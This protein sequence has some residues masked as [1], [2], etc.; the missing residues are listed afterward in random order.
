[1]YP[2]PKPKPALIA[3]RRLQGRTPTRRKAR[4]IKS[5]PQSPLFPQAKLKVNNLTTI[6]IMTDEKPKTN[7]EET[8]SVVSSPTASLT[9]KTLEAEQ[10][11]REATRSP[12][13]TVDPSVRAEETPELKKVVSAKE[14]QAE[15]TKIM[16]SGEGVE[17]P[18]GVTLNLISLAL[19][20]SVFL[21]ALD[22]T[23]VSYSPHKT[24]LTFASK[25]SGYCS[26]IVHTLSL[27]LIYALAQF[28]A[29]SKSTR[30]NK[31]TPLSFRLQLP[32]P[33]S[34][35]NFT[36][37][38]MLAGTALLTYLQ[39]LRSNCSSENSIPSSRSNGS[40]LSLLGSSNSEV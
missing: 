18:T 27:Q 30:N 37:Y 22:N 23:I 40:T 8:S 34:Q 19:C 28:A 36:V 20:L 2:L 3:Y 13:P 4:N 15:L 16:T 9:E 12:S 21:M 33:K 10:S 24:T 11:T 35:I 5:S 31:L 39:L 29:L 7:M 32:F 38:Q 17:Y 25:N 26:A 14:A 1:L 6:C